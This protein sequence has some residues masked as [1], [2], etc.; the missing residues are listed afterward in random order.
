MS[1]FSPGGQICKGIKVYY[2]EGSD[3]RTGERQRCRCNIIMSFDGETKRSLR[4]PSV[5]NSF[6]G[7]DVSKDVRMSWY[8]SELLE[9]V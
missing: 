6:S 1:N 4:R 8:A 7:N 2:T 3:E 9:Y 5:E